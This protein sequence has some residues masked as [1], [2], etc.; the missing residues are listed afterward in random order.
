MTPRPFPDRLTDPLDH[1]VVYCPTVRSTLRLSV[2][3]KMLPTPMPLA[4]L[5]LAVTVLRLP[6]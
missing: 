2:A 1:A 4:L 3:L 5:T 6:A